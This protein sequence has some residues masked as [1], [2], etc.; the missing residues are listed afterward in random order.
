MNSRALSPAL[1]PPPVDAAVV[2]AS[3]LAQGERRFD[4][5]NY[6][7]D[8]YI[9]RSRIER[10]AGTQLERLARVWQPGRLKGVQV[11]REKGKPFLAA[12][13]VF[14]IRPTPRKWLSLPHTPEAD[15]RFV[16]HGWI[17]VTRSGMVGDAIMAYRPLDGVIISDD[18][19][20]VVPFQS[21]YT[22]YSYSYLRTSYARSMLRSTKY[23]NVI[24]HL[25]PEH[26]HDVPI[27]NVSDSLKA[28]LNDTIDRCFRLR[29]DSY[30]LMLS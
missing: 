12:T 21:A 23:G 3:V 5:E 30:D 25:E 29:D 18:L 26:L 11:S 24:K 16:K 2:K 19:L 1:I 4:A 27:P 14:N 6:L 28:T 20:R 8:G 17:L 13:Q 22:G 9:A 7:S 15:E 10:L